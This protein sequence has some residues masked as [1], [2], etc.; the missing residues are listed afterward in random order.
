MIV[1]PAA[2]DA[3]PDLVWHLD[4]PFGDSSALPT[5]Y[6]CQ[7]ARQ[8]VTVALSGDGGDEV[9]AGYMRYQRLD[10]WR[11]WR[12]V[13]GWMRQ[14]VFS[15]ISRAM[16]FT[17]P[18][19]NTLHAAGRIG[20][21][22]DALGPRLCMYPYILD[23]L[24]THDLNAQLANHDPVAQ[25]RE[26]TRATRHLDPVSRLQHLDT[27]QYL[28]S[29]ILMKVDRMSMANSLEVRAPLLDYT[30]VEYVATL[31]VSFKLRGNVS[32]HLLRTVCR[33]MLPASVLTKPKQGFAI[34]EGRW[35]R[36]TL[37]PFAEEVLLDRRSL[38][39]GYFRKDTLT[40]LLR[41]HATGD[42]KSTRLNSSHLVISYAVF[43]LKKK[44]RQATRGEIPNL[45]TIPL[46]FMG[47]GWTTYGIYQ[48]ASVLVPI[49]FLK[50][51][52]GFESEADLLCLR[53]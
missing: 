53:Y 50:V 11:R 37:R 49:G 35:F 39:R 9:F 5:Y 1:K 28:P 52:R 44:N 38:A 51:S 4:E 30:L 12:R 23:A 24:C 2:L 32:K 18:G 31:P 47:G 8:H 13:P 20:D 21:G 34:P 6:V 42:R 26:L 19:W 3:L 48:A 14:G 40:R 46:I 36:T 27:L 45:A 16:P 17:W 25:T 41:H 33:R 7:A 15:R 22:D 43:C 10:Q 29:D